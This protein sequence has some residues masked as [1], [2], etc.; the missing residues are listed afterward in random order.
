[1]RKKRKKRKKRVSQTQ[2]VNPP[3]PGANR[4]HFWDTTVYYGG[5]L[6]GNRI[7]VN[8]MIVK[9][10]V[11]RIMAVFLFSG[12]FEH[13]ICPAPKLQILEAPNAGQ[14]I[15]RSPRGWVVQEKKLVTWC[16]SLRVI[17]VSFN[18]VT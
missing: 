12:L 14:M 17:R 18:I 7:L 8:I 10:I 3:H 6:C 13:R 11:Y 15:L 5:L 1:M 2:L 4:A 9:P 16:V